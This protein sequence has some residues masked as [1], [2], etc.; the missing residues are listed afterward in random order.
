M[1]IL[2]QSLKVNKRWLSL[3][4]MLYQGLRVADALSRVWVVVDLINSS[5]P[6]LPPFVSPAELGGSPLD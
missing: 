4:S 1:L 6:S 3:F 5:C 2:K